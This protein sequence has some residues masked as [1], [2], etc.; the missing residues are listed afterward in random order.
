MANRHKDPLGLQ[1]KLIPQSYLEAVCQLIRTNQKIPY[2]KHFNINRVR[3]Q[4]SNKNIEPTNK[5]GCRC[6]VVNVNNCQLCFKQFTASLELQEHLQN[7]HQG[8]WHD[9]QQCTRPKSYDPNHYQEHMLTFHPTMKRIFACNFCHT[10]FSRRDYFLLNE[11]SQCIGHSSETQYNIT[12]Y[13]HVDLLCKSCENITEAKLRLSCNICEVIFSRKHNLV[14]H[15]ES[16]HVDTNY[17]CK[18]CEN[19]YSRRDNL[20]RHEKQCATLTEVNNK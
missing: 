9:C 10:K 7:Y 18:H 13:D 14:R 4:T 6:E 5:F 17:T 15:K 12:I 3:T 16:Q 1:N 8:T 19:N 11:C 2:R 20:K